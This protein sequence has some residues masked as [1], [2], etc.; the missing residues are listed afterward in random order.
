MWGKGMGFVFWLAVGDFLFC[1]GIALT[2]DIVTK[3]IVVLS[4]Y[5]HSHLSKLSNTYTILFRYSN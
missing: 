2:E 3:Y 4:S 1:S 5:P